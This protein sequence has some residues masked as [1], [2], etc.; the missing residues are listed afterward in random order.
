[1]NIK[2]DRIRKCQLNKGGAWTML[3]GNER[4][5]SV[6]CQMAFKNRS[7]PQYGPSDRI[8]TK[9]RGGDKERRS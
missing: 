6:K 3:K 7:I 4:E 8:I 1:M 2:E 9:E 5:T